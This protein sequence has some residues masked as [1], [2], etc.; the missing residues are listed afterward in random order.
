MAYLLRTVGRLGSLPPPADLPSLRDDFLISS[1][2]PFS[3]PPPHSLPPAPPSSLPLLNV[4][5]LSSLPGW[6]VATTNA[7]VRTRCAR[8]LSI[9][10]LLSTDYFTR[11][12]HRVYS[13][14][15]SYYEYPTDRTVRLISLSID[16]ITREE[17]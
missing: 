10:Q 9:L 8:E 1:L 16:H 12:L 2:L 17:R 14:L 6:R 3:P 11:K 15:P 13:L 5:R 7:F 4:W